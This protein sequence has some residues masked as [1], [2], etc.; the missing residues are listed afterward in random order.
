MLIDVGC[1]L[2]WAFADRR[3]GPLLDKCPV[4]MRQATCSASCR[5][6][7]LAPGGEGIERN[8]LMLTD[9]TLSLITERRVSRPWDWRVASREPLG[10]T[11]CFRV[12]SKMEP[13]D[14]RT[15]A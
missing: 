6:A 3:V 14:C 7:G 13:G 15:S 5:G 11:G 12:A 2:D 1:V 4:S 8:L 10:R 9:V